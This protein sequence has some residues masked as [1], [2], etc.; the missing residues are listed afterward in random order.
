M[1]LLE[2][3]TG[4]VLQPDTDF[5]VLLDGAW[6][7]GKTH[8]LKN[9]F[10]PHIADHKCSLDDKKEADYELVYISL[11]G[12]SS[13]EDL[14]R[15][16]FTEINPIMK[17]KGAKSA[18]MLLN[19]GLGLLSMSIDDE[20]SKELMNIFGGIKKN[21][22]LVFDDLERLSKDLLG[23]VLGFI[24]A[25]TEHQGLKVIIIA[26]EDIIREKVDDYSLV[27]EKLIRFTYTYTPNLAQ[28]LPTFLIRYQD[29]EY[30][31]FINE[32]KDILIRTFERGEHLNLRTL[33][34]VLDLAHNIFR[35][36]KTIQDMEPE[37][38]LE[39]LQ[40][41]FYFLLTYCIEYK[42]GRISESTQQEL[43]NL[44]GHLEAG[45]LTTSFFNTLEPA[46]TNGE[47]L[48]EEDANEGFIADFEEKYIEH[49]SRPYHYYEFIT[50]YVHSG[51]LSNEDLVNACQKHNELTLAI[52][53]KPEFQVFHKLE[54]CL[55]L[56]DDEFIQV[57]QSVLEFAYLGAYPLELYPKIFEIITNCASGNVQGV[58]IDENLIGQFKTGMQGSL[59]HSTYNGRMVF[60]TRSQNEHLADIRS[61]AHQLNQSLLD[62]KHRELA[63]T[64]K[65]F[66]VEQDIDALESFLITELAQAP[67]FQEQYLQPDFFAEHFYHLPNSQKRLFIQMINRVFERYSN[68]V[69]SPEENEF[70]IEVYEILV[71]KLPDSVTGYTMS[72]ISTQEF[73]ELI[74]S[75]ANFTPTPAERVGGT[76]RFSNESSE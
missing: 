33:R 5:A 42:K 47:Q 71:A 34:F 31:A 39:I 38:G 41:F 70:W 15:K 14:Q 55:Q 59:A 3:L 7:S 25:Y 62:A 73:I 23:E 29:E 20:E 44:S 6:G 9:K 22:I 35:Q 61:Y 1:Q 24:N 16:L 45:G 40:R 64:A 43:L 69:L 11:F 12:V 67:V 57:Y 48:Q 36:V 56:E 65:A 51:D 26:H 66:I 30:T 27:K 18:M 68:Q 50:R 75:Y 49:A 60:M 17:T 74:S 2:I 8:F 10:G 19:K 46:L 4:Y 76:D 58:T 28:V 54:N 13:V 37:A 32:E 52:R 72:D 63:A 53:T 21:R